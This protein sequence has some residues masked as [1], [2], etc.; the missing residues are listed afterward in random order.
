M[1]VRNRLQPGE[2]V[3][4]VPNSVQVTLQYSESGTIQKIWKGL[5]LSP[6]DSE[7]DEDI[8]ET[9]LRSCIEHKY[10]PVKVSSV[11]GSTF[12]LGCFYV[13]DKVD[14]IGPIARIAYDNQLA[15]VISG[16]DDVKFYAGHCVCLANAVHGSLNSRRWLQ[17]EGFDVLPGYVLPYDLTE[18]S[19]KSLVKRDYPFSFPIISD[20]IVYHKSGDVSIDHLGL[21]VDQ[22]A[23]V[24]RCCDSFGNIGCVIYT[25]QTCITGLSYSYVCDFDISTGTYLVF[26][27]HGAIIDSYQPVKS[28]FGVELKSD[29]H[30]SRNIVCSTCG[31][32]LTVPHVGKRFTC[33]DESCNSVLFPRVV[34]LLKTLGLDPISYESYKLYSDKVGN[35]FIV[36]D[37]LSHPDYV[38]NV[39][40]V[41]LKTAI[42]S[43][44]PRNVLPGVKQVD[45]LVAQC[46]NSK[47]T[48]VYYLSHPDKLATDLDLDSHAFKNFEIWIDRCENLADVLSIFEIENVHITYENRVF[49]NPPIFRGKSIYTTGKFTYGSRSEVSSL[50]ESYEAEVVSSFDD[51]TDIILI[52][53]IPEGVNGGA[54]NRAKRIHTPFMNESEFFDKY[55]L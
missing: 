14:A 32:K 36:T 15:D 49:D 7:G 53:D 30:V 19:F 31:R 46:N 24:D 18:D 54:I 33:S 42:R 25:T 1:F 27:D 47:E 6:S 9:I 17:C 23:N 43:V 34:H 22:V 37:I 40:N 38:E 39:I 28:L 4:L 52:G 11:G 3:T 16:S 5:H 41:D 26:D 44:I 55:N 13:N 45:A 29:K 10:F 51:S 8:T 48:L 50:L 21:T 12:V 2:F 20:Y 35:A